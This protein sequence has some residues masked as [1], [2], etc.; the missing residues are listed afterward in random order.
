M[1]KIT[2]EISVIERIKVF[3]RDGIQWTTSLNI[4]EIFG[5]EHKNII[6]NI[7][8]LECSEGFRRLNFEP[9]DYVDSRGKSQPMYELSRDGFSFLV[10]GFTGAKAAQFKE[11]YIDAF[12]A[13]E[14]QVKLQISSNSHQ[15]IIQE[16]LLA[17]INDNQRLSMDVLGKTNQILEMVSGQVSNQGDRLD[18]VERDL[19]LIKTNMP[20]TRKAIRKEDRKKHIS[21]VYEKFNGKCP[22]CDETQIVD[23]YRR[24]TKQLQID[25]AMNRHESALDKTWAICSRCNLDKSNGSIP[26]IDVRQ[27]FDGYQMKMR[28]RERKLQTQLQLGMAVKECQH[29]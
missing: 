2:K 16:K 20:L 26:E 11:A 7:E 3:E 23:E 13:M 24:P 9:R 8:N 19:Y 22:L 5:K 10:M 4:A 25:H 17:E 18:R 28:C 12:N 6:R 14:K 1:S 21:L 29:E 27:C 15:I